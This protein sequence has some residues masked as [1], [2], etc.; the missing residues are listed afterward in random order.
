MSMGRLSLASVNMEELPNELDNLNDLPHDGQIF[1]TH[2]DDND[3]K[4]SQD[5]DSAGLA[6]KLNINRFVWRRDVHII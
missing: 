2:P 1:D 4:L 3:A 6:R 5:S